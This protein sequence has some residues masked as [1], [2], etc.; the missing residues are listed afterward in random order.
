MA[1]VQVALGCLHTHDRKLAHQTI[2][3]FV[4]RLLG[5]RFPR[6]RRYT[7]EQVYIKLLEDDSTVPKVDNIEQVQ[8]MLS[9]VRW[10]RELGPPSNVREARN[11]VANMLGIQLSER[12][13]VGPVTKQ[14][15][16]KPVDEF[17]TYQS[18][19]ESVR[20]R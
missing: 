18:L 15:V 14:S 16:K 20:T 1:I 7:A 4:M 12:D 3:P 6:I 13:K 5:H 2:F 19:V 17:A 8:S 9:E 10:D 11:Q